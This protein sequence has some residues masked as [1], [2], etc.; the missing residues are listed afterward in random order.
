MTA[1]YIEFS[2][3]RAVIDRPTVCKALSQPRTAVIQAEQLDDGINISFVVDIAGDPSGFW[4]QIMK[5]GAARIHNLFANT[6]R[7]WDIHETIAV[8]MPISRRPTRQKTMPRCASTAT[9]GQEDTS[10]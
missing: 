8:Q 9:P 6:D 3:W 5:V 10:E 7:E 1:Q 4:M 2:R